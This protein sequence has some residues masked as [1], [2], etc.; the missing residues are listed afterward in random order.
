VDGRDKPGPD[1]VAFGK[2]TYCFGS[3]GAKETFM[4]DPG[5]N[6][7]KAQENFSSGN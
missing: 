4:K 1:G 5:A 7:A 2:K 3:N 6:I